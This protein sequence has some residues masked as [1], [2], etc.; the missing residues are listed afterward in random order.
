MPGKFIIAA[1][2]SR[3]GKITKMG[4]VWDGNALKTVRARAAVFVTAEEAQSQQFYV[5]C[6]YPLLTE[7]I[8]VVEIEDDP[9]H[10]YS[11]IGGIDV[12]EGLR[13]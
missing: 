6:R 13:S 2:V 11:L 7:M 5:A 12:R 1:T 10:R 3:D 4:A 8:E 9:E